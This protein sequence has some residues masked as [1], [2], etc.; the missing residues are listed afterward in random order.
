MYRHAIMPYKLMSNDLCED[1]FIQLNFQL[2]DNAR[3][4]KL[5]FSRRQNY[6]VG[7]NILLNR[8]CS[9][10]NITDKQWLNLGLDSYKIKCKQTFLN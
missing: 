10:N 3:S 6:D 5:V 1:E 4:N 8:L 7:K 9:I 2:Y